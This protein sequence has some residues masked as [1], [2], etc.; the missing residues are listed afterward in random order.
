MGQVFAAYPLLCPPLLRLRRA[1]H[2]TRRA[3]LLLRL[4]R[5]RPPTRAR[6]PVAAARCGLRLRLGAGAGTARRR[7]RARGGRRRGS[8]RCLRPLAAAPVALRLLRRRG[9]AAGCVPRR[10]VGVRR[11]WRGAA[12][13]T[14]AAGTRAGARTG[15]G[16]ARVVVGRPVR[17][18]VRRLPA[19]LRTAGRDAASCAV[20]V[21]L[22][23]N[24]PVALPRRPTTSAAAAAASCAAA[25]PT[26]ALVIRTA[27]VLGLR[28]LRVRGL[29]RA[30]PA[31]HPSRPDAPR[32]PMP[33]RDHRQ[34]GESERERGGC[35]GWGGTR[36]VLCL[37]SS[38]HHTAGF[39]RHR[40]RAHSRGPLRRRRRPRRLAPTPFFPTGLVSLC[41]RRKT[42][43]LCVFVFVCVCGV[44]FVFCGCALP[45]GG[46]G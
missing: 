30:T 25:C 14:L 1:V 10:V 38:P 44:F 40:Q 18:G 16:A 35:R 6:P 28:S 27:F 37:S 31:S 39:T 26:V 19:A 36:F 4:R 7:Q 45:V 15:A 43:L 11:R 13:R 12:R 17:H 46:E 3:G 9:A 34:G 42:P 29:R 33:K 41:L 20:S 24:L 2:G 8:C 23:G 32:C 5:R 21:R 22:R